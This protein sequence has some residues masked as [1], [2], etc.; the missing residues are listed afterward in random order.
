MRVR[1]T[2]QQG[3][4]LSPSAATQFWFRPGCIDSMVGPKTFQIILNLAKATMQSSKTMRSPEHQKTATPADQRTQSPLPSS[5]SQ[6]SSALISR[7]QLPSLLL[8]VS[9]VPVAKQPEQAAKASSPTFKPVVAATSDARESQREDV[10]ATSAIAAGTK[11]ARDGKDGPEPKHSKTEQQDQRKSSRKQRPKAAANSDHSEAESA[12]QHPT[13]RARK[14]SKSSK[15][16]KLHRPTPADDGTSQ[17]EAH[18]PRPKIIPTLTLSNQVATPGSDPGS[19]SSWKHGAQSPRAD[20]ANRASVTLAP[21]RNSN[22]SATERSSLPRQAENQLADKQI[23]LDTAS[24]TPMLPSDD[25]AFSACDLDT[26]GVMRVV[27]GSGGQGNEVQTA[28]VAASPDAGVLTERHGSTPSSQQAASGQVALA[29]GM[30]A[31]MD[32]LD[33][34][35]E[36]P[37]GM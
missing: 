8:S 34:A 33:A 12:S 28:Q 3:A 17:T 21:R 5:S 31:L 23:A 35:L 25:F 1:L 19:P 37:I 4:S 13:K 30:T 27:S 29:P 11:R 14:G 2:P 22:A 9:E 7:P 10:M 16:D 6:Q 20:A 18:S 26:E 32:E 36:K 15:S 24:A